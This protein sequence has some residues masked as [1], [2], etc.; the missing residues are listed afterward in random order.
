MIKLLELIEN[1]KQNGYSEANASAKVCQ[2]LLLKAISNSELSRNV[3]IK[4]GVVMR[5]KTK[6]IRRATQDLDIDF[7]KYS[8]ADS[9]IDLFIEKVNNIE[10]IQFIRNGDIEELKQQDY[11]GKRVFV[12]IIDTTGY[13]LISKIDLGVHKK[14]EI[15]QEE[16]CFDISFTDDGASLLINTSEQMFSEKLRSLLK[17]G[18][19][20]TRYKDIFDMYYLLEH[21]DRD[22]LQICLDS[23]IYHDNGMRENNINDII[24]RMKMTFNTKMY[25]NRIRT[26]DK[27]WIDINVDDIFKTIINFLESLVFV[28]S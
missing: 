10:G 17:F 24:N 5:S 27:K 28:E 16:Y 12:K 26:S 14:F 13:E 8:L 4:G 15:T 19:A 11:H 2:D 20:S 21:I 3:T 9:S 1:E 7:I 22:K 23:Y 25:Q 6:N 18:P